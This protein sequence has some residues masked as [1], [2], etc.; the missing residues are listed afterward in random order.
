M[1]DHANKANAEAQKNIKRYQQQQK[2]IQ[3]ALEEEQRNR[4][5]LRE[6][7][8]I[9][10]RRSNALHN[11]LEES[12][13]LLEQADRGRRQAEAELAEAHESLNELSASASSLCLAKR[14]LEGE[15]QTLHA[16]LDEMLNEAKNSEEKA[17]KAMV[18][19]ARLA[20]EL[21]AE[22]EH[23]QT[24]EKMRKALEVQVKEMQV[25]LEEAEGN[26]L[27]STKKTISKLEGRVRE[28]E[29]QLDD[30]A[31]RHADAQKNLRKC[32]RRIK[33]LTFQSDEDKKNHERMQDLVDKLQQ[34]I[35][36]YKRQIEEAEEI[37][38]L[39]LS[40]FRKAQQELEER[41]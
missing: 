17:K 14:K 34:K 29:T 40:K 11:E 19:A 20:D 5:D 25:R 3:A 21:R 9:S 33:E 23:A 4:D 10:E 30:E 36:T 12:R 22:Q 31:R 2:E 6:Q 39:N 15:L 24:Q 7:L 38:A 35:K 8:G 13:T 28:L 1:G 26:A 32:E 16:D 27:K 18:D 41:A 37:A